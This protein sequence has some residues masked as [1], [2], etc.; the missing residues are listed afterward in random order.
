M[1]RWSLDEWARPRLPLSRC[2]EGQ[3]GGDADGLMYRV[4]KCGVLVSGRQ[5]MS[6]VSFLKNLIIIMNERNTNTP[7]FTLVDYQT[8]WTQS[9]TVH[10]VS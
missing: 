7:C 5:S 2:S 1:V 3:A 6:V 8:E 10:D 9:M 4:Q